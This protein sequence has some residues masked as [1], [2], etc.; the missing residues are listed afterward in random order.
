MNL[1][2]RCRL[3]QKVVKSYDVDEH[4]L[5]CPEFHDKDLVS[6]VAKITKNICGDREDVMDQVRNYCQFELDEEYTNAVF[7]S[8]ISYKQCIS[9]VELFLNKRA[10]IVFN[11]CKNY[12]LQSRSNILNFKS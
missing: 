2:G 4:L 7:P 1:E 6:L 5:D 11:K 10:T 12:G 8:I 3:C 9:D